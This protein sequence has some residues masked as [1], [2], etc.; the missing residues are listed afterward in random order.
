[1]TLHI[2]NQSSGHSGTIENMIRTVTAND[3]VILIEDGV[4]TSLPPHSDSIIK[5]GV[6]VFV[7]DADVKARGLTDKVHPEF[8]IVDDH[9]FVNLCCQYSKTVSWF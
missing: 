3:A 8:Q 9:G 6:P 5:C 7:L 1:M 2:L 4:Y